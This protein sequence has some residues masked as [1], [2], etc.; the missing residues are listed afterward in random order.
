MMKF[1]MLI[2]LAGLFFLTFAGDCGGTPE[3]DE[4]GYTVTVKCPSG[5]KLHGWASCKADIPMVER[6]LLDQ[7][8]IFE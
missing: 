8:W 3:D 7:C 6:Q 2:L 5:K 1:R 4:T